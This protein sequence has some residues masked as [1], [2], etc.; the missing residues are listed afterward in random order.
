[1]LGFRAKRALAL[2]SPR[3]VTIKTGRQTACLRRHRVPFSIASSD[4]SR[5]FPSALAAHLLWEKGALRA[6]WGGGAVRK[7]PS[8]ATE[9][10]FRGKGKDLVREGDVRSQLSVSESLIQRGAPMS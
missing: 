9:P 7:K 1:M 8:P 5:C 3:T 4:P 2:D 10:N 6:C